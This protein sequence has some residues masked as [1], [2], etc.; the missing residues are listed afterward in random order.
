MT[1]CPRA[2]VRD[3]LPDLLHDTLDAASRAE[4]ERHVTTCASCAQE[5][6]LLRSMRAALSDAPAVDVTRIAAAVHAVRNTAPVTRRGRRVT[7][8]WRH[9]WRVAAAI[10]LVALG[11]GGYA[12]THAGQG[13]PIAPAVQV[14][15]R[16]GQPATAG[17]PLH[18]DAM[19]G[20]AASVTPPN[21]AVA[22]PSAGLMLGAGVSDLPTADIRALLDAVNQMDAI[23]RADPAP[24]LEPAGEDIL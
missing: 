14:A 7:T 16:S 2:D 19:H 12:L 18:P 15:S 9:D 8:D 21:G 23:P 13:S 5:L 20:A 1:D 17:A 4:V 3:L 22:A 24:V 10:L 6:E 11:A